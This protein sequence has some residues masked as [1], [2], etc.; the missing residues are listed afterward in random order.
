MALGMRRILKRKGLVKNLLSVET[1]GSTSVICTDK[2]GTLTQGIM[3]VVKTDFKDIENSNLAMVLANQQKDSLEISIW[4]YVND[5]NDTSAEELVSK[6]EKIFEEPFDSE[7]K[8][9]L[10]V[11]KKNSKEA[12]YILGAPEIVLDFC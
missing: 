5:N 11:I 12:G 8:Y 1:L 2:T 7:K 6:S 4:K 10:T 3:Q 9:S